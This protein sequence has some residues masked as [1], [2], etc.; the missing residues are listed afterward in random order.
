MTALREVGPGIWAVTAGFF[1]SNSYI[2]AADVPGGA[3]LI[4]VGMDPE[5][6]A[7]ALHSLQL[8]PAAIFCTH[9]HF[10]HVAGAAHFQRDL[11]VPVYLHCAD[12]K[13]LRSNNLLLMLLKS[14]YRM[15]IPNINWID[16][17]LSYPLGDGVVLTYRHTPGHTPGSCVI[18]V[19][20]HLFTGDTVYA[21]DMGLAN[22]AGE[23]PEDLRRSVTELWEGLENFVVHPGHGH[24]ATGAEIK[25]DNHAL[26]RFIG[27]GAPAGVRQ[28][29]ST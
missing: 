14:G 9:G 27:L 11:G 29:L 18:A 17:R 5:A 13:V 4:D 19:R 16:G 12:E 6:I 20:E 3:V 8:R 25:R 26:A 28:D 22:T 21:R 23:K 15:T 2:V 24:S 7:A 10:D 1:P